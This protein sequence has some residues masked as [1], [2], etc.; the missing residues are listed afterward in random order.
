M[1]LAPL[2]LFPQET[3]QII[4]ENGLGCLENSQQFAGFRGV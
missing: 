4:L 1:K 2:A 3:I